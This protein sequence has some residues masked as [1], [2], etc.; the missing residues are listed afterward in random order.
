MHATYF[1]TLKRIGNLK[2]DHLYQGNQYPHAGVLGEFD[3]KESGQYPKINIL[4]IVQSNFSSQSST[5]RQK[6]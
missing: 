5:A 6:I 4:I 3:L 2:F 1:Q